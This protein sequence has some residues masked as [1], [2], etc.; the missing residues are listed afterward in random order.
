[1]GISTGTQVT[2]MT[3]SLVDSMC[4]TAQQLSVGTEQLLRDLLES[5][6]EFAPE[7][8]SGSSPQVPAHQ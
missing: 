3:K 6:I 5:L 7:D 4:V 8:F 1:M 2:R